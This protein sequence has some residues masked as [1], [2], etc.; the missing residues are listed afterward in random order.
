[1]KKNVQKGFTLIELMIV[2]AI[3]G[4]LASIAITAYQD[5]SIRARIGEALVATAPFKVA[6]GTY[7]ETTSRLPT[8]RTQSGQGNII[9]KYIEGVTITAAGIIS[10][11]IDEDETGVRSQTVDNMFLILEPVLQPGAIDWQCYAS[12]VEDGSG[13]DINLSRFIPSGCR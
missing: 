2:I 13:D 12:N 10:I 9:T 8:S 3:L 6:L 5:Y 1:M 11:D 7:F 4:I